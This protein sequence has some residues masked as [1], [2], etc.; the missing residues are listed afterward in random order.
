[1]QTSP[2][3]LIKGYSAEER[4]IYGTG[5]VVAS[6]DLQTRATA[7]L[8]DE[9]VTSVHVRPARNNCFQARIERT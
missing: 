4:I 2:N 8:A 3:Y 7:M 1:M 5:S 6:R 9:H